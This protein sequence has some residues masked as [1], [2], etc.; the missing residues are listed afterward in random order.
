MDNVVYVAMFIP[1]VIIIEKFGM[2]VAFITS[3][4][5]SLAGSWIALMVEN[6]NAQVFGQLLIDCG[7]PLVASAVTMVP[8]HWFPYKER[9]YATSVGIMAGMLGYALGD[10]T[11]A[12]FGKDHPIGFAITL[13]AIGGATIALLITV[14]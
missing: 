14:W 7:F 12:I 5:L 8:A 9:F 13:T 6:K 1:A 10:T 3:I 11:E 2:R 4:A